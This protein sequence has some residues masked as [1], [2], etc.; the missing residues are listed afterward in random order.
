MYDAFELK[1]DEDVFQMLQCKSSFPL[2]TMIEL[3][4]M[5]TRSP[6]EILFL[7][8]TNTPS[9]SCTTNDQSLEAR[10]KSRSIFE[11]AYFFVYRAF[12]PN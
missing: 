11:I 10:T 2:N 8:T 7:L 1:T 5:F 9:S 3:Y 6:E 12:D 4:V